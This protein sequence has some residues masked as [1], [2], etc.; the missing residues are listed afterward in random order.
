MA[1][2]SFQRILELL[3]RHR[4]EYVVVGGVAAVLRGAPVSTF[5]I[6]ALIK[7]DAANAARLFSGK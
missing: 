3:E 4:V 7:V 1:T 2:Q 5:D 6:D